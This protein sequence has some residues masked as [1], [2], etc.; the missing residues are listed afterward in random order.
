MILGF[1]GAAGAGA[2]A[3][4]I[5]AVPKGSAASGRVS[6]LPVKRLLLLCLVFDQKVFLLPCRQCTHGAGIR[7]R[8]SWA[9][10]PFPAGS[11]TQHSYFIIHP[12]VFETSIVTKFGRFFHLLF[13]QKTVSYPA[14]AGFPPQQSSSYFHSPGIPPGFRPPPGLLHRH[15]EALPCTVQRL[16][17]NALPAPAVKVIPRQRVA[18]GRKMHPDLMGATRYRHTGCKAQAVFCL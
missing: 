4:C 12:A 11:C 1:T 10:M 17:P 15:P 2:K 9:H 18:D 8:R 7:R 6:V 5:A 14:A 3:P 13:I 16:P